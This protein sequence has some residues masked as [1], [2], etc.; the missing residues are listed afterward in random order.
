MNCGSCGCLLIRA[1]KWK[2]WE[3]R[4][5]ICKRCA[6]CAPPLGAWKS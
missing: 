3:L 5:A 1:G 2:N 6:P 4:R